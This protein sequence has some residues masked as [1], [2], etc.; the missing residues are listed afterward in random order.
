[1]TTH[2]RATESQTAIVVPLY[3]PPED[4]VERLESL[5]AMGPVVAVDDGSPPSFA[6]TLQAIASVSGIALIRSPRNLGI[7]TALNVGIRDCLARG[8][9]TVVTFDQDSSPNPDHVERLLS[10][11]RAAP[12]TLRVGVIGPGQVDG[13]PVDGMAVQSGQPLQSVTT[14]I[15]SGMAIPESTWRAVGEFDESLFIDLVDIDYCLRVRA[16][17]LNVVAVSDLDMDHCLG[18]GPDLVRSVKVGKYRPKA[19]G[20]GADRRY[21]MNRNL[22]FLLWRHA[23]REPRWAAIQ[24]RRILAM[25]LLACTVERNR[26]RKLAAILQGL[27]HGLF[28]RRGRRGR[29]R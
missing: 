15:Q 5:T 14:L 27:I 24:T 8:A 20:H 3:C 28:G 25:D 7:A 4:A 12:P 19:T 9:T 11:L 18:L 17:A 13:D 29:D 22:I 1:M 23:R 21:Y 10:A 16:A 26:I 6:A 2:S